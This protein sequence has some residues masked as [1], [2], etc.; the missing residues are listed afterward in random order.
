LFEVNLEGNP[1]KPVE[2]TIFY[3]NTVFNLQ[4]AN[5]NL[6][7]LPPAYFSNIRKLQTLDLS[8]NPLR[9]IKPRTFQALAALDHLY[10]DNC[11]LTYIHAGAFD[12]LLSLETLTL[13][14]NAFRAD[15][16]WPS[17]FRPLSAM[18][19]LEMKRSGE[20]RFAPDTFARNGALRTV[21]LADNDM[22]S[23]LLNASSASN[24]T[25]P[26]TS[27]V[28]YLDVGHCN[29]QEPLAL[30]GEATALR[31]LVLSGNPSLGPQRVAA[32]LGPL[33]H[34]TKL[35]LR[36]CALVQLPNDT[37]DRMAGLTEL[38]IGQNPW[39]GDTL[40][41]LL[42][43]CAEQLEHL[44]IGYSNLEIIRNTVFARMSRL[45]SLVLSGNKLSYIERNAFKNLKSLKVLELNNCDLRHLNIGV[46]NNNFQFLDL[47]ELH[48]SGNPLLIPALGP[49][50]PSKLA[51]LTS[52]DMSRCQLDYLPSDFFMTTPNIKRLLLNDNQLTSYKYDV[53]FVDRLPALERLDLSRNNLTTISAD[54]FARNGRLTTLRLAGNPWVC[55]C[56]LVDLWNWATSSKVDMGVVPNDPSRSRDLA[57]RLTCTYD[58]RRSP[59]KEYMLRRPPTF[60]YLEVPQSKRTWQRYLRNANCSAGAMGE[61]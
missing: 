53:T 11:G 18:T 20:P 47:A 41:G 43:S 17:V 35:T 21:A 19:T 7:A 57:D 26:S 52:L 30:F 2:D 36:Q 37:F 16:D 4:L 12:G 23:L 34:L 50:L 39:D 5:C 10:L 44:D 15:V 48:V 13:N 56:E 25:G 54:K 9:E 14:G 28:Q 45:G 22:S 42:W 29:L 1:L 61:L 32:I 40:T 6:T 31:R 58:V 33:V 55:D 38:D 27:A 8:G 60:V 51:N 46:F 49:I 3:S 59:E 24:A